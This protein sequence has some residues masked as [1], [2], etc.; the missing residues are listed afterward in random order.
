MLEE[1]EATAFED[2]PIAFGMAMED[3][4]IAANDYDKR[5]FQ[6]S[7]LETNKVRASVEEVNG[8]KEETWG[9]ERGWM[10]EVDRT[11]P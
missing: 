11:D 2:L 1:E 4:M 8:D 3:D 7:G 5:V 6:N 10:L 9:S